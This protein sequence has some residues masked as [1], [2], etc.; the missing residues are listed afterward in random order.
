MIIQLLNEELENK[1]L[2][3][4]YQ[5]WYATK[6]SEDEFTRIVSLDASTFQGNNFSNPIMGV[7]N[8]ASQLILPD[9]VGTGKAY[10]DSNA[11]KIKQATQ[12]FCSNRG[13]FEIKNPKAFTSTEQFVNY[14]LN[15]VKPEG[16]EVKQP[17]KKKELTADEKLEQLRQQQAPNIPDLKTLKEICLLDIDNNIESGQPGSVARALLIPYYNRSLSKKFQYPEGMSVEQDQ[18]FLNQKKRTKIAIINYYD[19]KTDLTQFKTIDD[20]LDTYASQ[21]IVKSELIKVLE[22]FLTEGRDY[23]IIGRTNQ[24]DIIWEKSEAAAYACAHPCVTVKTY[25]EYGSGRSAIVA[26]GKRHAGNSSLRERGSNAWCTGWENSYFS[27]YAEGAG[28]HLV[29]ILRNSGQMTDITGNFQISIDNRGQVKDMEDGN[30]HHDGYCGNKPRVENIFR[31]DPDVVRL[32]L[33]VPYFAKNSWLT[34]YAEKHGLTPMKLNGSAGGTT[35]A[36][37]EPFVYHSSNDIAKYISD[38]GDDPASVSDIDTL[39]IADGVKEI[40]A[41][42][43]ENWFG[44][45][46]IQFPDSL[47]KIGARAFANCKGLRRIKKFGNNLKEIGMGAFERCSNLNGSILMPVN[48]QK[49]GD[50][51]FYDCGSIKFRFPTAIRNRTDK[52]QVPKAQHDWWHAAGRF[53]IAD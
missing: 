27:S 7:G 35:Y 22:T 42:E 25:S 20:F 19:K 16:A 50:N 31:S 41:F 47:E 51:C 24:H 13:K 29:A 40:P 46:D 18:N 28:Y 5:Q 2:D 3:K 39:I 11:D 8:L 44:L 12:E 33:S 52:I 6:L 49:F 23:E 53:T 9:Y 14:V 30:N 32:L 37:T 34:G 38:H 36:D 43:F 48:F 45:I 10:I 17:E 15:G 26:Y 21:G 1:K 4:F